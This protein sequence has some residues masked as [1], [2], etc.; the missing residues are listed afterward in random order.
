MPDPVIE[1]VAVDIAA[2]PAFLLI[3][4]SLY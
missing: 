1:V 4:W 2:N 3:P